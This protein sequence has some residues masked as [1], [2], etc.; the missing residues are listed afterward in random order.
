MQNESDNL[1]VAFQEI[2]CGEGAG[3]AEIGMQFRETKNRRVCDFLARLVLDAS[4]S[5]QMR[6]FAYLILFTVCGRP[7]WTLP[8]IIDFS[9][10]GDLDMV[11]VNE[12]LTEPTLN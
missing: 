10:P 3:L 9:I 7:V 5:K 8:D 4:R 1:E 6:V 12:C 2:L 11:F